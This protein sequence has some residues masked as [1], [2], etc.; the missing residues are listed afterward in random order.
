MTMIHT[1][2]IGLLDL[3]LAATMLQPFDLVVN[4]KARLGMIF[5][6][7]IVFV[8]FQNNLQ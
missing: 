2:T 8:L 1:H 4:I 7:G 6:M 5:T 3:C